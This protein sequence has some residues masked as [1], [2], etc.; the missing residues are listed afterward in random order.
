[1]TSDGR[2]AMTNFGDAIT[3]ALDDT[4][5]GDRPPGET[6]PITI[7][8]MAHHIP[9]TCCALTDAT[10]VNHC[11]HPSPPTPPWHRRLRWRAH[12]HWRALRLRAGTWIAG[13]PLDPE[14]D[15]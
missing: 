5:L 9:I 2:P 12:D 3:R 1:M 7:V 14:D 15:Q 11:Q 6:P 4:V 8:K 10:G 13:L